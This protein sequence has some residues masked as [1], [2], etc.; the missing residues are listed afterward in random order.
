M[1][2]E[3]SVFKHTGKLKTI[4]ETSMEIFKKYNNMKIKNYCMASSWV[5]QVLVSNPNLPLL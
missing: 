5:P 2:Q 3:A 1:I 4:I